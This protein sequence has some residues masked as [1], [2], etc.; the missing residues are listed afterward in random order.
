MERGLVMQIPRVLFVLKKRA[1]GR[2]WPCTSIGSLFDLE[3][4]VSELGVRR[5]RGEGCIVATWTF[6]QSD[7][8]DLIECAAGH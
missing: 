5:R 7:K 3:N 2:P 6:P 1:S 4:D 8:K